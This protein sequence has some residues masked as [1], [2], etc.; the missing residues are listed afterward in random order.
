MKTYGLIGYPLGH[1]FSQSYFTNKFKEKKIDARYLNF[2]IPS[3]DEFEGL[4]KQHPYIAGINVTIPYKEQILPYL[5]ELDQE[6]ANIGAVNVI[7]VIWKNQKRILKGYNSDVVGFMDSLQPLLKP[8]HTKALILGSGGAS[9][10]VAY[11]LS[12][13]GITYRFVSRTPKGSAEVSY[14]SITSEILSEYK[15]IINTTPVGLSPNEDKCPDIPYD[16]ISADHL[17]YDLIY[18]PEKT[19]FMKKAAENGAAVKNGLEMLHLQAKAAWEI[20][21]L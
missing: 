19:L 1:S 13:S 4:I 9:K 5:D 10:A 16:A 18:N 12:K 7:K 14:E 17:I 11:G 3:I 6:A 8:V 21:N 15:L 20:W 2:P